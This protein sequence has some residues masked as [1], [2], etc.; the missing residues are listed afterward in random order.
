M[1]NSFLL[2]QSGMYLFRSALKSGPWFGTTVCTSSCN[3][4]YSMHSIGLLARLV[5]SHIF[6]VLVL[7][8]P[9]LDVIC[10]ICHD[11]HDNPVDDS[12]LSMML[13]N[14]FFNTVECSCKQVAQI[15]RKY[16][17]WI[18]T[19][20]LTKAFHFTPNVGSAHWFAAPSY[21]YST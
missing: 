12:I 17:L 15:M 19:C 2:F 8:V 7:Q 1:S 18:H 11:E 5:L 21:K 9:H 4:T 6:L 14:I 20:L 3:T 16:L 10:L 13:G